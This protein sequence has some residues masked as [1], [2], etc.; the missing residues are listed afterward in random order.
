MRK[1]YQ[2]PFSNSDNFPKS[3][4]LSLHT[5]IQPLMQNRNRHTLT[6]DLEMLI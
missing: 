1:R 3:Q 2:Q 6:V 4:V 5:V